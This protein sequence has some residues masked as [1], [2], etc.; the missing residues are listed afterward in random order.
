MKKFILAFVIV[1]LTFFSAMDTLW[2]NTRLN[3]LLTTEGLNREGIPITFKNE[4]SLSDDRGVQ[5]YVEWD[6]DGEKRDVKVKWF[7]SRDRL[8][9]SLTLKGFS[10]NIVR[11]YISFSTKNRSQV[12]IPKDTGTYSIYLYIGEELIGISKFRIIK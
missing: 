5:Y 2:A 6:A 4:F 1:L 7:D 10:D 11:D 12:V 8:I 3:T 9:N